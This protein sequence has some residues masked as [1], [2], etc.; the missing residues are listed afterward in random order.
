MLAFN[1]RFAC[2]AIATACLL[3]AFAASTVLSEA[4]AID[5]AVVGAGGSS[6][7]RISKPHSFSSPYGGSVP[8]WQQAGTTTLNDEYIHLT[9]TTASS[10]GTFWNSEPNLADDWE[11]EIGFKASGARYLGGDGF[12][13]WYTAKRN[14]MGTTF[15][16][17]RAFVGLGILFDSY[18]N[19]NRR[20]NPTISAFRSDG[21]MV[22]DHDGDGTACCVLRRASRVT[23][24]CRQNYPHRGRFLSR[25]LS[26]HARHRPRSYS[27]HCSQR[28]AEGVIRRQEQQLLPALLRNIQL[29]APQRLLLRTHR[30]HW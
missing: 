1:R 8:F 7:A 6:P 4:A 20:D 30:P 12:A 22:Y 13:F 3:L 18:D 17:D 15:G 14:T 19:D 25:E 26:Q 10:T 24:F 28:L 11:V 23:F 21:T 27:L 9:S 16:N 2:Q 5:L 29:A